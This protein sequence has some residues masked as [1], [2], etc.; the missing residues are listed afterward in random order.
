MTVN[1]KR[2]GIILVFLLSLIVPG[3][4]AIFRTGRTVEKQ[5]TIDRRLIKVEQAIGDIPDIRTKQ[6]EM[7]NDIAWIK[8][9]IERMERR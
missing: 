7:A 9:A 6:A 2:Q 5:E 1:G 3:I 4:L 8:R